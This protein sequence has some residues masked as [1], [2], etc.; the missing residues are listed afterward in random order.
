MPWKAQNSS[1]HT[2]ADWHQGN[3][4]ELVGRGSGGGRRLRA[5]G[6]SARGDGGQAAV[7]LMPDT[8]GTRSGCVLDSFPATLLK[9]WSSDIW[10]V[11]VIL[12]FCDSMDCSLAG[13]SFQGILQERVLEWGA[14]PFSRGSYRPR[15]WTQVSCSVG[16]LFT[17]WVTGS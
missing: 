10:V 4:W 12:T 11:L 1:W 9:K 13:S 3:R 5:E 17:I 15:D 16:R 7:S 2:G 6:S 8:D 14:I